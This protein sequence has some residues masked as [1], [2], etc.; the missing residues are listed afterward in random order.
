MLDEMGPTADSSADGVLQTL[1]CGMC[2]DS[3]GAALY[4][5]HRQVTSGPKGPSGGSPSMQERA[6]T[7]LETHPWSMVTIPALRA[8]PF[9]GWDE[10][11]SQHVLCK[12]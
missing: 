6:T 12:L 11:M 8:L 5:F 7:E 2:Y 3:G 9:K 1:E 4:P 10:V